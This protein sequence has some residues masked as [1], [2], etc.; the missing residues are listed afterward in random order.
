DV[1]KSQDLVTFL[2]TDNQSQSKTQTYFMELNNVPKPRL[3]ECSSR[4][5]QD[6]S[7]S[8]VI[9]LSNDQIQSGIESHVQDCNKYRSSSSPVPAPV[10][11]LMLPSPP[12]LC[13]LKNMPTDGTTKI[14]DRSEK[15]LRSVVGVNILS[16]SLF[17]MRVNSWSQFR[18]APFEVIDQGFP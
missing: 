3:L 13:L 8:I 11:T 17:K 9:A 2:L 10:Y 14:P 6:P 5:I 12:Q 18:V 16:T 7:A 4:K 1:H 15:N